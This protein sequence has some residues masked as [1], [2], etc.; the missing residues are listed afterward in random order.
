[1][2]NEDKSSSCLNI[3]QHSSS[4]KE[5]S[6]SQPFALPLPYASQN[7]RNGQFGV[8]GNHPQQTPP[9]P[10]GKLYNGT[11]HLALDSSSE[12]QAHNGRPRVDT[13][14]RSQLLQRYWPRCTDQELQQ[15]SIEYPSIY[16]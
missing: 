7:E 13:R 2:R 14:G 3:C 9:P 12:A 1:M 15:I 8:I 10:P 5:D 4:L 6:S 11:V 16:K